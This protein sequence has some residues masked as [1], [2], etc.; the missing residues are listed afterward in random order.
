MEQMNDR[1]TASD[2]QEF[3]DMFLDGNERIEEAIGRYYSDSSDEH[4]AAVLEIVRQRMHEDGHFII[5]VITDEKDKDRFSLRAIQTTD[6]KFCYVA[7]TSYAECEKRQPSEV[8][9]HAIDSML[10]I[11]QGAKEVM[12]IDCWTEKYGS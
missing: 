12:C 9:S 4:F 3:K 11:I 1:K 10:K 8:I 5:P 7:F 6:G 2:R